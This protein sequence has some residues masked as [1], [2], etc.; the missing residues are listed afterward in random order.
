MSII[1][2]VADTFT[3]RGVNEYTGLMGMALA[4]LIGAVIVYS[5]KRWGR[6]SD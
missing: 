3:L 2:V 5:C 1:R 4:L 6:T